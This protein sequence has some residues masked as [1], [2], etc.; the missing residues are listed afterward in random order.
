LSYVVTGVNVPAPCDQVGGS[1]GKPT[2]QPVPGGAPGNA[3]PQVCTAWQEVVQVV[4][5]SGGTVKARGNLGLPLEPYGGYGGL[6]WG[7]FYYSDWF[8]GTDVAQIGDILA[9][10]RW[11]TNYGLNGQ[12]LPESSSLYVVDLSNPD[13]PA[14]ASV[15]ITQDVSNS[16][17]GNMKVVNSNL[18]VTHTVWSNAAVQN[19]NPIVRYYLDQIDLSDRAHPS[20]KTHINVPGM[21]VGGSGTD[22]SILYTIDYRYNG[23]GPT[24]NDLDVV[25]LSGDKAY[26]QSRTPLDGWVGNVFVRGTTAYMSTQKVVTT[27]VPNSMQP[28]IELHQIDLSNPAHPIDRV[29]SG[30]QGWGWLVEV[31][32]DRA[33]V[34]SG[35]GNQG[36]D[37][38]RLSPNAAPAYDQFVRTQGWSLT[39]IA[40]Q[41]NQLFL[42]SGDWGVQ[43][44]YLQ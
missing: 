32:G 4:D 44:V 25:K 9:F 21:L 42:S 31:Q 20:V 15:V 5:V 17:W 12:I 33:L 1:S 18:F 39:S 10:R 41:G 14:L 37:I 34:T 11:H 2:L 29:A 16:W 22:P 35:W 38:Y 19:A 28:G 43:T 36:L 24:V 30:Q 23:A 13:Q 3:G 7:G 27:Y 8:E 40:R 6:G 26:L